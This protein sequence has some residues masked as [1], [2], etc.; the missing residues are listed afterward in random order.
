[1]GRSFESVMP[2]VGKTKRAEAIRPSP[3]SI[4]GASYLC[5]LATCVSKCLVSDLPT[6]FKN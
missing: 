2:G 1:M 5:V 4:I 3:F 6:T